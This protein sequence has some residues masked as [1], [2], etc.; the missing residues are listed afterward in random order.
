MVSFEITQ[1]QQAVFI[2]LCN[3]IYYDN[4]ERKRGYHLRSDGL[5]GRGQVEKTWGKLNNENGK[6]KWCCC[7][8]TKNFKQ[9]K[10]N[11]MPES[12]QKVTHI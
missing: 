4:N 12:P 8:L 9:F 10:K 5:H 1:T 6:G 7:P 11:Y 3:Y 2:Y